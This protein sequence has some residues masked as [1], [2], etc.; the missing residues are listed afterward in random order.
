MPAK[1]VEDVQTGKCSLEIVECGGCGFHMGIDATYL[2]QVDGVDIPCPS[3]G[4]MISV[5]A[6]G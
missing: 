2:E 6:Y 4:E 1:Y 3:C 5:E